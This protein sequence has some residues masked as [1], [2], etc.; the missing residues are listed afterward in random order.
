MEF[1]N[2][3][4]LHQKIQKTRMNEDEIRF[5]LA[6]IISVLQ[7]LHS[8]KIVYRYIEKNKIF[9]FFFLFYENYSL[10]ML[11]FKT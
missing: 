3:D 5:Y 10:I 2:G 6:E 1:V 7:F 8:N 4:T 11:R 9:L